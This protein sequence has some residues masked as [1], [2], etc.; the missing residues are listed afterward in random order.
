M[1]VQ[2]RAWAPTVDAPVATSSLLSRPVSPGSGSSSCCVRRWRWYIAG[3]FF[4]RLNFCNGTLN[5]KSAAK[6][7][8]ILVYDSARCIRDYSWCWGI[9]TFPLIRVIAFTR[10]VLIGVL[11]QAPKTR[12]LGY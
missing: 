12:T 5:I 4:N 3:L 8:A 2:E 1:K 7:V 10:E 11:N 6:P 9:M